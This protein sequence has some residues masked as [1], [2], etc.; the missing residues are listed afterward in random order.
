MP[1]AHK[2]HIQD[3]GNTWGHISILKSFLSRLT[4]DHAH[5]DKSRNR[6]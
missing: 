4:M 3:I 6:R 5:K 1:E 2:E